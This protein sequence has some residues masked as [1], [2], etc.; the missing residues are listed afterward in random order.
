MNITLSYSID[1][2]CD[3]NNASNDMS[4]VVLDYGMINGIYKFL[5]ECT[6]NQS[7]TTIK[8]EE[9]YE[10]IQ[11]ITKT[12]FM[13]SIFMLSSIKTNTITQYYY[14]INTTELCK[15]FR[16]FVDLG[17]GIEIKFICN[18]K[19]TI[20]VNDNIRCM[21]INVHNQLASDIS[22]MACAQP[23]GATG[24]WIDVRVDEHQ[25]VFGY[26]EEDSYKTITYKG[27]MI[28]NHSFSDH[29]A[30]SQIIANDLIYN[31]LDVR[32]GQELYLI[33]NS[34]EN[35]LSVGLWPSRYFLH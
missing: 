8:F 17:D 35:K 26:G 2:R 23:M 3:K 19:L 14:D 34:K 25:I 24:P 5:R 6:D 11:F 32:S 22:Q 9:D 18:D 4:H 30:E 31:S 33:H 27:R 12:E 7:T 20:A 28:T 10:G 13:E 15:I 29:K 16:S 21:K 1:V